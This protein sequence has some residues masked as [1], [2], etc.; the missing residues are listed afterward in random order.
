[1]SS[2]TRPAQPVKRPKRDKRLTQDPERLG[3]RRKLAGLSMH[4][5]AE[6]ADLGLATVC[7]L[8]NGKYSARWPTLAKLAAAL[9]CQITD[10][11]PPEDAAR[12][13]A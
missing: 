3:N 9:D 7:D 10:L 11:I 6:S 5:L 12:L 8:E 2:M 4:Q 1:M 13:T